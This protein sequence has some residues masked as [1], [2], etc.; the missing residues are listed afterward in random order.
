VA[1]QLF[2]QSLV[3]EHFLAFASYG[4]GTFD[5]ICTDEMFPE[6][7]YEPTV[8]LAPCGFEKMYRTA[9]KSILSGLA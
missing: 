5:Y 1:Y 7:G 8:S 2:A 4:D 3:P 6:G 9:I